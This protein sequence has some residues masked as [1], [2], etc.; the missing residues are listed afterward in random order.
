M[1][2]E[3][4]LIKKKRK[5]L[6]YHPTSRVL[7]VLELLQSRPGLVSGADLAYKLETDVRTIRRYILKLQDVGIPIE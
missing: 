1:R 4:V 5:I 6:L 2:T 3:L 7:S